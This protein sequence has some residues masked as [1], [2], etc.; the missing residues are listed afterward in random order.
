MRSCAFWGHDFSDR[1]PSPLQTQ[2]D[3]EFIFGTEDYVNSA[4]LAI[5]KAK[6]PI[7]LVAAPTGDAPFVPLF[8]INSW[9]DH[10]PPY[11]QMVDMICKFRSVG[12]S[13]SA[14]QTLTIPD[15]D[16]HSF[17]YWSSWDGISDPAKTVGTDVID[18][19]N[20]HLK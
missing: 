9:F 1:T 10:P 20:A 18:F 14:Y 15:S 16:L 4:D 3:P 6:S 5:L 7:S 12:V 17:H 13:D 8:M 19:L 11:N 2:I